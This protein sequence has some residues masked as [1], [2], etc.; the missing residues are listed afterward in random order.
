[1]YHFNCK[2]SP[3]LNLISTLLLLICFHDF[4]IKKLG[5]KRHSL[6]CLFCIGTGVDHDALVELAEKHFGGLRSTYESQDVLQPCRYTGSEVS[7]LH[8]T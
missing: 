8:C 3:Q 4:V 6:H 1:M 2:H 5:E 7:A